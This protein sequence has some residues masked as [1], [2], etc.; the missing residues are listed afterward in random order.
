MPTPYHRLPFAF[1]TVGQDFG[2]ALR[3]LKA[4]HRITRSAWATG[5]DSQ[6]LALSCD[7]TRQ[8]P[9]AGFWSPHNRALAEKL[10]GNATVLPC[11]T[12]KTREGAV[13]MGW[14]PTQADMLAEDWV[15]LEGA[16]ASHSGEM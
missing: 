2:N 8:V 5:A 14:T 4:G 9:A 6:W 13:Q 16:E 1:A 10:G 3:G 11:I 7:G 12:L 15:V